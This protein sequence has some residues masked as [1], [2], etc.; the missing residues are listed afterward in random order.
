MMDATKVKELRIDAIPKDLLR[1]STIIEL[2][3]EIH[4]FKLTRSF[5]GKYVDV[6][7]TDNLDNSRDL[8][9]YRAGTLDKRIAVGNKTAR[10]IATGANKFGAWSDIYDLAGGAAHNAVMRALEPVKY[11]DF[12]RHKE[13]E[14]AAGDAFRDF[15][16]LAAALKLIDIDDTEAGKL[17]EYIDYLWFEVLPIW[18]NGGGRAAA[19]SGDPV[20]QY[21]YMTYA[22]LREGEKNDFDEKYVELLTALRLD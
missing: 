4:F 10:D 14:K 11:R 18:V 12:I 7:L 21:V 22:M 1:P 17:R 8:A 13:H 2:I 15:G 9:I 6:S 5:I 20:I 16:S 19:R 3:P